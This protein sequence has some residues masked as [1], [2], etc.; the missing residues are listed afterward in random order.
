MGIVYNI[1]FSAP[2]PVLQS[3]VYI[4]R[5][6]GLQDQINWI[7]VPYECEELQL[8]A[9]SFPYQLFARVL[10][11]CCVQKYANMMQ[12]ELTTL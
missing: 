10:Q 2:R 12:K 9:Y 5:P 6:P 8:L 4:W 1:V 3:E 7:S 11:A